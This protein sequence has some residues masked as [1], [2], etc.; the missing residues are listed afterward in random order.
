MQQ[1]LTPKEQF[2]TGPQPEGTQPP[3]ATP[4][5]IKEYQDK[6]IAKMELQLPY[7]KMREEYNRITI[8]LYEQGV[9]LGNIDVVNENNQLVIPGLLGIEL[10]FKEQEMKQALANYKAGV[11]NALQEREQQAQ[12]LKEESENREGMQPTSQPE[13]TTPQSTEELHTSA[14]EGQVE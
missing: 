5:A 6:E 1:P 13:A 14:P 8:A 2:K 11:L 9:Q 3:P 12:K 7:M 10:F 4:E